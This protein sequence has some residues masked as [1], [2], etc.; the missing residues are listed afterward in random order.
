MILQGIAGSGKTTFAKKFIEENPSFIRVNRDDLRTM[1]HPYWIPG[2]ENMIS[3]WEENIVKE[4][5]GRDFSVIVD[6]THLKEQ[7]VKRW[8]NIASKYYADFEIKQF[9]T[10]LEQCIANDLQRIRCVGEDVIRKQYVQF[11]KYKAEHPVFDPIEQDNTLPNAVIVDLDGSL[12]IHNGRN[13]FDYDKVDTDLLNVSLSNVLN[14][15][16]NTY[17]INIIFMSGRDSVCKTKTAE[18]LNKHGYGNH[19]LY[20]RTQDDKRSDDIVKYEL[21]CKFVKDKFNVIAVFDDRPKVIRMWKKIGLFVFNV[22][23]SNEF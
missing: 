19:P 16:R 15:L 21:F 12:A 10:P 11:E 18:W 1:R 23:D 13:P 9:N 22:G 20:M 14:G 4:A 5:L 7:Y 3:C 2:Q 17:G 6:A 8:R